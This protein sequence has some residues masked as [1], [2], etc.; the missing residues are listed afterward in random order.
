MDFISGGFTAGF[1]RVREFSQA[2]IV[3]W[4][5]IAV[6]HRHRLVIIAQRDGRPTRRQRRKTDERKEK[7]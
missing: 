3:E 5:V 2:R 7:A 1:A 6:R 4:N